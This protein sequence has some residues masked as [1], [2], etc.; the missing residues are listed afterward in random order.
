MQ[1]FLPYADFERTAKAL[2]TRR[3]GKQ[4]VETLQI[5]RALHV[6]GYGWRN[7]PAVR[8]WRG[9]EE[10]LASYGLTVCSEWCRRGH[11]DTCADKIVAEL[12]AMRGRKKVRTQTELRT[13]GLLPPW[14][15]RRDLHRSHRSA[16]IRKDPAWYGR[17]FARTPPDIEYVW[18]V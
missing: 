8:M 6:P 18:P 16:L 9:Y 11:G 10:S 1:T 13:A 12:V 2:D 14:L 7:H 3:L 17:R 5:M 15:G 4:R